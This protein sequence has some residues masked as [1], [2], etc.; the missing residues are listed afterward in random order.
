MGE[1]FDLWDSLGRKGRLFFVFYFLLG[2]F[3]NFFIMGFK[4]LNGCILRI[5]E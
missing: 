3:F 1:N 4:N 2:S 5:R